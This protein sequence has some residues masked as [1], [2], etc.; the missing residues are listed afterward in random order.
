MHGHPVGVEKLNVSN[1]DV[2]PPVGRIVR[3]V[4]LYHRNSIPANDE[5]EDEDPFNGVVGD[6]A[7]AA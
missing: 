6:A 7:A 1:T 5:D 3:E 2:F 4:G